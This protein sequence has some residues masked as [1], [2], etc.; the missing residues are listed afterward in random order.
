V[1]PQLQW[2]NAPQFSIWSALLSMPLGERLRNGSGIDDAPPRLEH[3]SLGF[4]T[5]PIEQMTT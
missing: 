4:V 2:A 3:V 5:H 1:S